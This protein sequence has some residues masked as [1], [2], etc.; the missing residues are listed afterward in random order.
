MDDWR[1]EVASTLKNA[2]L[3][4]LTYRA[5]SP[6]WDHD[7]CSACMAKFA[8]FDGP[9]LQREGY[10]TCSDFAKGAEYEWVCVTCFDELKDAMGWT[11]VPPET[12]NG[13]AQGK[14][15]DRST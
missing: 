8:E 10:A 6:E 11:E 1:I 5:W 9:D 3:Q 14:A 7:H 15:T 13:V 4:R 12:P 2:R